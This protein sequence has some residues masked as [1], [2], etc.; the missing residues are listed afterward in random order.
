MPRNTISSFD[1][2]RAE[3]EQLRDIKDRFDLFDR[4]ATIEDD[5]EFLERAIRK[6]ARQLDSA[7]ELAADI[8]RGK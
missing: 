3:T 6:T 1:R 7:I 4:F 8:A 2:W 5:F